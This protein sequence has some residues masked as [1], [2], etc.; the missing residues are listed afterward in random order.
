M[1][2]SYLLT[3]LTLLRADRRAVTSIEYAMIAVAMAIAV[4]GGAKSIGG[5]LAITFGQVASEL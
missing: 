1:L 4:L 2:I 5:S 3:G